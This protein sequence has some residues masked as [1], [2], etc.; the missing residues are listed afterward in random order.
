MVTWNQFVKQWRLI[1]THAAVDLNSLKPVVACENCGREFPIWFE[2]SPTQASDCAAV[3]IVKDDEVLIEGFYGS[4][5]DM[6]VYRFVR[7]APDRRM[8]PVCDYCIDTWKYNGDI[9]FV[10]VVNGL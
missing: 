1:G 2:D 7:N 8:D 4:S 6:S 3:V 9:E 10:K 5:Y